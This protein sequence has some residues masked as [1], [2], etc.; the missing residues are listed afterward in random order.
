M[1]EKTQILATKQE[2]L[3]AIETVITPKFYKRLIAYSIYRL[4]NRFDIKYDTNRGFRGI[5]LEDLINDLIVS[6]ISE[7]GRNWNKIKFPDFEK[8]I[9]SSLDSLIYN[10]VKKELEKTIKTK[11]SIE[12]YNVSVND[13]S[14][15]NDD[16]EELLDICISHLKA[17]GASDDEILLFEP[18]LI[19]KTKRSVIAEEYGISV[20]EVTN[21]KKRLDRKIPA[22]QNLLKSI[23]Y[24]K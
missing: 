1:E 23:N 5:M 21:I 2:I 6:F 10:I 22:L 4:K 13:D 24:G 14:I 17:L 12:K 16:Y 3:Q 19:E 18:I 11:T 20:K 15:E 8:Q 9:F 7:K